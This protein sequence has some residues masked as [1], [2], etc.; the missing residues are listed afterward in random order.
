MNSKIYDILCCPETGEQLSLKN[1][2]LSCNENTYPIL[3]DIPWLFKKPEQAFLEWA[4]KIQTY[5]KLEESQLNDIYNS[6][7][8][9][10]NALTAQRVELILKARKTNL[11]DMYSRLKIFTEV[12]AIDTVP[13]TQQIHSYFDLVF[14]DWI[15]ENKELLSYIEYIQG[16]LTTK[17]QNV[18]I[19]GSGA[20]GLSY[21]LAKSNSHINFVSFE[22][23]PYLSFLS[24]DLISGRDARLY[25]YTNHPT[26]IT[27]TA[28]EHLLKN[29]EESKIVNHQNILGTFPDLPFRKKSFDLVIAPWFLDIIDFNLSDSLNIISQFLSSNGTLAFYGPANFHKKDLFDQYCKEE[30]IDIF[31]SNFE[32][33]HTTNGSVSYLYSDQKSQQRIEELLFTSC[34]KFKNIPNKALNVEPKKIIYTA[35]LDAYKQK[36]NTFSKI[37]KHINSDMTLED[38]AKKLELEF[39][40]NKKES[41]HY[42]G[43]FYKMILE[44][45]SDS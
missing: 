40:F 20:G 16:L 32:I 7:K 35:K 14:R 43:I 39:D 19:L 30:I 33:T 12:Q 8:S 34:S 21:N 41:L 45:S 36:I 13:D 42:A 11:E 22:H 3:N 27:Q 10:V 26:S 17:V 38:L 29:D 9:E 15:P 37:F 5:F 23:N 6:N 18:L 2:E 25:Q 28:R 44:G 24:H 31:E 1:N 4:S